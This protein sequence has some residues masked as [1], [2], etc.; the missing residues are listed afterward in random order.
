MVNSFP[1]YAHYIANIEM[2]YTAKAY[3]EALGEVY[4]P[5]YGNFSDVNKTYENFIQ[6]LMSVINRLAPFKIKG[7]KL[8]HRNALM[9]KF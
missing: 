1:I 4:F 8:I 3:K 2:V 6:K 9:E 7:V 5:N